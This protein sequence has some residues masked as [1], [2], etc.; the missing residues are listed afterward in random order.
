MARSILVTGRPIDRMNT[1]YSLIE[2]LFSGRFLFANGPKSNFTTPNIYEYKRRTFHESPFKCS[3]SEA[4]TTVFK[5]M[6]SQ[7]LAQGYEPLIPEK[8]KWDSIYESGRWNPFSWLEVLT[9][10][11]LNYFT[12]LHDP[13]RPKPITSHHK[14]KHYTNKIVYWTKQAATTIPIIVFASLHYATTTMN[15]AASLYLLTFSTLLVIKYTGHLLWF[16]PHIWFAWIPLS[17][18]LPVAIAACF[19]TAWLLTSLYDFLTT[20]KKDYSVMQSMIRG[21]VTTIASIT[22][23]MIRL[24]DKTYQIIFSHPE[25]SIIMLGLATIG[26]VITILHPALF[27]LFFKLLTTLFFNASHYIGVTSPIHS[28][29]AVAT[30]NMALIVGMVMAASNLVICAIK[31]L[32]GWID[33]YT[34]LTEE[35]QTAVTLNDARVTFSPYPMHETK[36]FDAQMFLPGTLLP[37][38]CRLNTFKYTLHHDNRSPFLSDKIFLYYKIQKTDN[39]AQ[40]DYLEGCMLHNQD[41]Y[42]FVQRSDDDHKLPAQPESP[43]VFIDSNGK[44]YEFDEFN[45]FKLK[46][47]LKNSLPL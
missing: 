31:E 11:F 10:G 36:S 37:R 13:F 14:T 40:L 21:F 8:N 3:F 9:L 25:L 12:Y 6:L 24:F 23:P 26:A 1:S 18:T 7:Q 5:T 41:R 45:D 27:L 29:E 16:L 43:Y 32:A 39:P 22:N 4:Y 19:M 30:L 20:K 15:L 35:H 44:T 42:V 2:R 34:M 28:M 47:C 46:N 33:E 17:W 38:S